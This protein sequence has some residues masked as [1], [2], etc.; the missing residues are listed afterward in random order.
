MKLKLKESIRCKGIQHR[1]PAVIDTI[2]LGLDDAEVKALVGRGV[3]VVWEDAEAVPAAVDAP[4]VTN[5]ELG[6]L[7]GVINADGSAASLDEMTKRE[8]IEIAK[9]MGIDTDGL[10]KAKLVEAI[11][12]QECLV[13]EDEGSTQD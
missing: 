11:R 10:S 1:P 6:T 7:D 13:S 9:D 5:L 3:A 4:V 12:A 2:E 8:L